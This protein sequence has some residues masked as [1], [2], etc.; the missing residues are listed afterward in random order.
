MDQAGISPA[1]AQTSRTRGQQTP[2]HSRMAMAADWKGSKAEAAG[3][4][5][6]DVKGD[7]NTGDA[8]ALC[9]TPIRLWAC[10]DPTPDWASSVRGMAQDWSDRYGVNTSK[11]IRVGNECT[12]YGLL[13]LGGY[14]FIVGPTAIPAEARGL[15]RMLKT[16]P[17]IGAIFCVEPGTMQMA[18]EPRDGLD[19]AGYHE[20]PIGGYIARVTRRGERQHGEHA[21]LTPASS[22]AS[23]S[24]VNLD[25][26][27]SHVQFMEFTGMERFDMQ[28]DGA[29]LWRAGKGVADFMRRNP[30]KVALVCSESGIARPCAVIAS[31]ALQLRDG[32]AR[33]RGQLGAEAIAQ[34]SAASDHHINAAS[35]SFDLIA[36]FCRLTAML[37][38]AGRGDPRSERKVHMLNK[39]LLGRTGKVRIDW[40]S[41]EGRRRLAAI[42]ETNFEQV[43]PVLASGGLP[44]GTAILW[45]RDEINVL[46]GIRFLTPAYVGGHTDRISQEVI[47]PESPDAVQLLSFDDYG[48]TC[49]NKYYDVSSVADWYR[50]CQGTTKPMPNPISR[51]PVVALL[52]H[53]SEK[54]RLEARF[55]RWPS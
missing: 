14:R 30:G 54:A 29:T 15:T 52:V 35:R 31:A 45:L 3:K 28:I 19:K 12:R 20:R 27:L 55:R 41:G 43:A 26:G 11:L 24:S 25:G 6:A 39:H 23:L 42:L 8:T 53:A 44:P 48:L 21:P 22:H 40:Q 16:Y 18:G 13:E 47:A 36:E 51:A 2:E 46:G 9:E 33:L 5:M 38:S 32:D 37:R 50:H 34:R 7:K 1:G 49:D 4:G 10:D 17:Q